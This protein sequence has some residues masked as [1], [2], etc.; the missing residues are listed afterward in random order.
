MVNLLRA[1]FLFDFIGSYTR[2]AE[3]ITSIIS[4]N[5]AVLT[6]NCLY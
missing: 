5:G 2:F 3:F 1:E 4:K 6:E